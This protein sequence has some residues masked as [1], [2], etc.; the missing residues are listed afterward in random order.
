MGF[1]INLTLK[2]LYLLC[3][4]LFFLIKHLKECVVFKFALDVWALSN[5]S[6]V[7]NEYIE[8]RC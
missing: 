1:F 6:T 3:E 4:G 2:Q 5:V 8:G 7:F